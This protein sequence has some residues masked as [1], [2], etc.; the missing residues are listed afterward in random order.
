MT[1]SDIGRAAPAVTR[2]LVAA[3]ADVLS[4]AQSRHTQEDVYLELVGDDGGAVPV[5]VSAGRVGAVIRKWSGS[6]SRAPRLGDLGRPG[7]L[8]GGGPAVRPRAP[9]H[10]GQ[11]QPVEPGHHT[12]QV[13]KGRYSSGVKAFDAAEEEFVAFRCNR[14][15]HPLI[16]AATLFAPSLAIP[17]TR[18]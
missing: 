1:V 3:G 16:L 5:S 7:D 15:R 2:A 13:R 6:A 17:L 14:R 8:P 18:E 11:A 4:I 10:R 12:L 9:H